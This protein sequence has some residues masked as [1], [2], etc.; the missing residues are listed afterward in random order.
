MDRAYIDYKLGV[1]YDMGF[2]RINTFSWDAYHE[3][4]YLIPQIESYRELHGH[5]PDLVQIDKIYATMEN[6][7]W[8]KER[9]IRITALPLGRKPVKTK[10][11]YYQRRKSR[12]KAAER[13]H[14]EGRFG[15][16]KN[17]YS[18]NEIR[19]KL[20]ATSESWV[21][22]IFFVMNLLHYEKVKIFGSI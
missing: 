3:S 11:N 15:Q 18:L 2:T 5:Y 19:A 13:N 14:I 22:C 8:L 20:K 10:E 9:D 1:S 6:R 17:G 12:K 16:G 4:G 7:K 21:A